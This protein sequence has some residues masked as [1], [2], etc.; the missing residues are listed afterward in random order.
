MNKEHTFVDQGHIIVRT[1]TIFVV[2]LD[3]IQKSETSGCFT[4]DFN[5]SDPWI[6]TLDTSDGDFLN[7]KAKVNPRLRS[8][9]ISVGFF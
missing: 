3:G 9:T 1:S 2:N 8:K 5:V 7:L 6:S 4:P